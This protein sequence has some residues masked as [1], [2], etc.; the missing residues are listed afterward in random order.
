VK[1]TVIR[2]SPACVCGSDLWPC[3]RDTRQ[4]GRGQDHSGMAT[5]AGFENFRGSGSVGETPELPRQGLDS[6]LTSPALAGALGSTVARLAALAANAIRA[7]DL[8]RA[9]ALLDEIQSLCG[10]AVIVSVHRG[11]GA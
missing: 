8:M 3:V 1:D 5:P 9:L 2:I 10:G 6:D 11:E 7:C 4:R